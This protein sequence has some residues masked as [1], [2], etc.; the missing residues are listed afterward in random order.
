[1]EEH[2]AGCS[3]GRIGIEGR[4]ELG[5]DDVF[6]IYEFESRVLE[7]EIRDVVNEAGHGVFRPDQVFTKVFA[8]WA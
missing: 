7:K 1:M 2:E 5:D 6:G 4:E 8:V 3:G